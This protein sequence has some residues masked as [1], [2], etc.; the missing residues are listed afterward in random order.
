MFFLLQ[1]HH[2]TGPLAFLIPAAMIALRLFIRR[3]R[4]DRGARNRRR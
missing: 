2:F 3:S 4:G 1:G